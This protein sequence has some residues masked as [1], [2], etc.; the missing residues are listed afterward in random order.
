MCAGGGGGG[1]SC[2]LS[3]SFVC[4]CL[5]LDYFV[6]TLV[7]PGL[8]TM[9]RLDWLWAGSSGGSVSDPCE[10]YGLAQMFENGAPKAPE[11]VFG[12]LKGNFFFYHMSLYSK[13]SD[14]CGEFKCG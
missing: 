1:G 2:Y 9:Q 5:S 7:T 8:R 12:L 10:S 3:L 4:G 11:N 13:C 6:H 14:F